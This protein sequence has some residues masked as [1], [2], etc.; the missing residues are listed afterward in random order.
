MEQS[1]SKTYLETAAGLTFLTLFSVKF[2]IPI[3]SPAVFKKL[4][5]VWPQLLTLQLLKVEL[6]VPLLETLANNQYTIRDSIYFSKELRNFDS[7]LIIASFDEKSFFSNI[8]LQETKDLSTENLFEINNILTIYLRNHFAYFDHKW[9]VF[10]WNK[11]DHEWVIYL[12]L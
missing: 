7:S 6:F 5:K 3:Y 1:H 4:G 11:Y 8:L 10:K 9:K 2:E 12:A